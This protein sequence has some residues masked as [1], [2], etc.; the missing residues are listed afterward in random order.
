M[1]FLFPLPDH[2][3][4]STRHVHLITL[5]TMSSGP[6]MPSDFIQSPNATIRQPIAIVYNDNLKIW[7]TILDAD[8][9][10]PSPRT[11]KH[12]VMNIIIYKKSCALKIAPISLC[13]ISSK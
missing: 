10:K 11:V 6:T 3:T 5:Y 9:A 13:N 2:I 12:V 8:Q 1:E 7:L 4:D